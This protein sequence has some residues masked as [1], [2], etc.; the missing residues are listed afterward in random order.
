AARGVVEGRFSAAATLA[1][2]AA[3][4]VEMPICVA[5]DAVVNQGAALDATIAGLLDRPFKAEGLFV[6]AAPPA[7]G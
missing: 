4:G 1:M 7:G 3:H 5:V 2:A 6:V